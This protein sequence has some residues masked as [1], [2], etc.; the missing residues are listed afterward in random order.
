MPKYDYDSTPE[1]A[2]PETTYEH[3]SNGAGGR[4]DTMFRWLCSQRAKGASDD[5]I[6]NLADAANQQ[7]MVPPLSDRELSVIVRQVLDYESGTSGFDARI[8][9]PLSIP[10][11]P[12]ITSDVSLDVL[13]DLSWMSP[14]NQAKAFLCSCFDIYD[15]VC[16]SGNLQK[17]NANQYRYVGQLLGGFDGEEL[18]DMME[19]FRPAVG[20]YICVNPFRPD[21]VR[22]KNE[23]VSRY[24]NALIECDVLPK[25]EQLKRMLDIFY[26]MKDNNGDENILKAIV[27]SGNKSYHCVIAVHAGT[28]AQYETS[29]TFLYALCEKNGLPIDSSCRNPSRMM[30]LPGVMRN[31]N[32]QKLVY[33]D[34]DRYMKSVVEW[35]RF[36]ERPTP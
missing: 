6:T 24:E 29:T 7:C 18:P 4:N 28:F 8:T 3:G 34:K 16:I 22:R 21:T 36:T 26:G 27:D 11:I 20:G 25:E 5:Q 14:V 35:C 33:A 2:M 15:V 9:R 32:M 10:D 17:Q 19:E 31:G 23:N 13:E 12:T 1:V 30:R